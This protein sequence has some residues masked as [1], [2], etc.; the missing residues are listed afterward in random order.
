VKYPLKQIKS[1]NDQAGLWVGLRYRSEDGE[2]HSLYIVGGEEVTA[3]PVGRWLVPI[4]FEHD[5][6]SQSCYEAADRI[7]ITDNSVTLSLNKNG[8]DSLELPKT[9]EFVALKPGRDYKKAKT[10]FAE[11][12]KR[13]GGKVIHVA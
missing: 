5:D 3:Q 1:G 7:A 4:Y 13:H 10:I 9:V 6:Q 11:M 12:R 8:R 2:Q